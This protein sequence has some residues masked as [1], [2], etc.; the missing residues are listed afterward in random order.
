MGNKYG[1]TEEQFKEA[2]PDGMKKTINPLLMIQINNTLGSQEECDMYKEN[3]ITYSSVL[4]TGKFK[5]DSYLNAV[6]YVGFKVMGMTNLEAYRR[7]FPEKYND[8]VER[9]VAG[10]DIASYYTAYNKSKLVNLIF[11]QTLIPVHILNAPAYQ[12]ALNVQISI[13]MD[14]EVSP[15]VRSDAADSVMSQTKPPE[16]KKVE[17]DIGIQENDLMRELKAVTLDLAISQKKAIDGGVFTSKQIAHQDII[18]MEKVV[19]E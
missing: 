11:A 10:K 2:L 18:E 16:V 5:M 1:L 19:D 15:K 6:R 3:L 12:Q 7:T 9:G 17:L 14:E 4:S 13:M 8:F